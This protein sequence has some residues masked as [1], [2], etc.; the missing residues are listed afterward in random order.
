M[1]HQTLPDPAS[2]R[3]RSADRSD[4]VLPCVVLRIEQP[5]CTGEVR[6]LSPGGALLVSSEP[7][8]TNSFVSLKFGDWDP[9][10]AQIKWNDGEQA[11][12]RFVR[13]LTVRQ[14]L[15]LRQGDA[16]GAP[17]AEKNGFMAR[18]R[19]LLPGKAAA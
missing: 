9:V 11:G 3:V 14:Y 7:L 19:G 18:L 1:Q 17:E 8:P 5:E 13:S 2:H 4:I 16:F 6:N 15:R 12:C 10:S